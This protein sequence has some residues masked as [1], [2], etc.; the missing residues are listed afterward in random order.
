M[1]KKS[2]KVT[3]ILADDHTILREGLRALLISDPCFDVIAQ[4]SDGEEVVEQA[5]V[6]KPDIIIMDIN[7]SKMN[8]IEATREIRIFSVQIKIIILSMYSDP[9]YVKQ[10]F[11]AGAN[12]YLVKHSAAGALLTAV[13]TVYAGKK[14][15]SPELKTEE[16]FEEK[17]PLLSSRETETLRYI[18]RGLS[19]RET[20]QIMNVNVHTVRTYR[21]RLMAKLGLHDIASLTRYAV[22]N[23]IV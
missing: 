23:N 9:I 17:P 1:S 16:L 10:A 12:G 4:S 5:R 20:S 2:K 11:R 7:M 6:L 22:K 19:S 21:Q 14:Y 15:I 18:A 13:R 8:G 3:I